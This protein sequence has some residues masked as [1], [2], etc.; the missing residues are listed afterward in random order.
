MTLERLLAAAFLVFVAAC[1]GYLVITTAS[2]PM[3]SVT[4][5]N[6]TRQTLTVSRCAN[7]PSTLKPGESVDALL[8]PHGPNEACI[9]YLDETG[10]PLGCLYVPTTTYLEGSVVRLSEFVRGVFPEECGD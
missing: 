8:S 2:A 6:D 4:I 5:L 7:D 10:T 3:T 1:A 9:V